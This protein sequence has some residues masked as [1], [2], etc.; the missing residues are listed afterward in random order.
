MKVSSL[1]SSARNLCLLIDSHLR[2]ADR[3]FR[4]IA[5]IIS[6][7]APKVKKNASKA[8]ERANET[9]FSPFLFSGAK[10]DVVALHFPLVAAGAHVVCLYRQVLIL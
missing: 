8:G 7:N 2:I 6:A 5:D 10:Q 9:G 3:N 4:A 1:P